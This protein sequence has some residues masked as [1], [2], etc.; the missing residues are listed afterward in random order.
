VDE[1]SQRFIRA[2][3]ALPFAMIVCFELMAFSALSRSAGDSARFDAKISNDMIKILPKP[4]PPQAHFFFFLQM[5]ESARN[6]YFWA[7][8]C[9]YESRPMVPLWYGF[10]SDVIPTLTTSMRIESLTAR[11]A[12]LDFTQPPLQSIRAMELAKLFDQNFAITGGT[13]TP[14]LAAEDPNLLRMDNSFVMLGEIKKGLGDVTDGGHVWRTNPITVT[15]DGDQAI[16]EVNFPLV[17]VP[18]LQEHSIELLLQP[19]TESAACV[20]LRLINTANQ[21]LFDVWFDTITGTVKHTAG[22]GARSSREGGQWQLVLPFKNVSGGQDLMF[23]LAPA[24]GSILGQPDQTLKGGV[25]L[26]RVTVHSISPFMPFVFDENFHPRF[27]ESITFTADGN[28]PTR[29]YRFARHGESLPAAVN[30]SFPAALRPS[31]AP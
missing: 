31:T 23:H 5:P 2:A 19:L 6:G 24:A 9:N 30:L 25:I 14:V 16:G 1:R 26:S 18:S 11:T 20:H 17:I 10:Q 8:P 3:I 28:T 15:D 13:A 29:V 4:L 22:A 7:F 21:A 12:L 27:I